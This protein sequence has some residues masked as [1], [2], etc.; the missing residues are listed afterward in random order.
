[1]VANVQKF[2]ERAEFRA[3]MIRGMEG[4]AKKLR[5]LVDR[6]R[7]DASEAENSVVLD[8]AE[9]IANVVGERDRNDAP[10][11]ADITT[12]GVCA[13]IVPS[14]LYAI[15]TH[16][17]TNAQE[18]SAEG[19][20]VVVS[21]R[22]ERGKAIIEVTDKGSGMSAEFIRN[23]LFVP[24]RSTKARGHGMGAYQARALVRAAGGELEVISAVGR[25]TT[26][27]IELPDVGIAVQPIR[28]AIAS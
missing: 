12:G 24:L 6:L 26:M 11:R 18:A 2:G 16:L 14:D 17:V 8:P 7:P 21:L 19:D 27:R 10:V 15:L 13:R 28:E 25:G 1:M 3:D 5:D 4:A 20:E 9:T 23:S 22:S